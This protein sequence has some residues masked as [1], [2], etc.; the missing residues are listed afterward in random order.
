MKTRRTIKTIKVEKRLTAQG[1][2]GVVARSMQVVLGLIIVRLQNLP[3]QA[4]AI[5]SMICCTGPI[6]SA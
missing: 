2:R 4:V 1:T 5:M 3:K 6:V